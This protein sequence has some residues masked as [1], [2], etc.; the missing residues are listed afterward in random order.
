VFSTL[1]NP[2]RGFF[3]L[4]IY[5][6]ITKFRSLEQD[7]YLELER[8]V[9]HLLINIHHWE[10]AEDFKTVTLDEKSLFDLI[11][12]LLRIQSEIRKEGGNN[13]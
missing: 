1:A 9:T 8:E 6:M 13:E 2:D 10:D 3:I 4:N 7:N 12:Q 11:G 5:I